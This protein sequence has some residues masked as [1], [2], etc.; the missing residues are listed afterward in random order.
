[1]E[2]LDKQAVEDLKWQMAHPAG[3]RQA[4]RLLAEAGV[5]QNPFSRDPGVTEFNAGRM[6]V[7][8]AFMAQIMEFCPDSFGRM[9][10]EAASD[11]QAAR[12][13]EDPVWGDHPG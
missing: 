9:L 2:K 10:S 6:N 11:K 13:V 3:R 5:F 4:W 8:Q 12:T 7:G 1:M